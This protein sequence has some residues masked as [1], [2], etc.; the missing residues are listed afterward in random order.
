MRIAFAGGTPIG[1]HWRRQAALICARS[2]SREGSAGGRSGTCGRLREHP[3]TCRSQPRDRGER[4]RASLAVE[5]GFAGLSDGRGRTHCPG[6]RCQP[7]GR[8]TQ[9]RAR[10][11]RQCAR[12]LHT[13]R[14]RNAWHSDRYP[15]LICSSLSPTNG[16]MPNMDSCHEFTIGNASLSSEMPHPSK[17]KTTTNSRRWGRGAESEHDR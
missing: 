9:G 4:R 10:S 15:R 14:S 11:E 16:L 1:A 6:E 13:A 7:R 2:W 8:P 17:T 5:C 3:H 12:R